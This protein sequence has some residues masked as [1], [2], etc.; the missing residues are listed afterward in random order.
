MDDSSDIQ[1]DESD[2]ARGEPIPLD[3]IAG[4]LRR[5][6]QLRSRDRVGEKLPPGFGHPGPGQA[7]NRDEPEI[8]LI[9]A[10]EL[11]ELI[12]EDIEPAPAPA[13]ASVDSLPDSNGQAPRKSSDVLTDRLVQVR[14][15]AETAERQRTEVM[16]QNRELRQQVSGLRESMEDR[17]ENLTRKVTDDDSDESAALRQELELVRSRATADL[18]TLRK[19]LLEVSQVND[20]SRNVELEAELQALRQEAAVLRHA[21]KEKDK[22]LEDLASQCRNLEDLVEDRD[23]DLEQLYRDLEQNREDSDGPGRDSM[24]SSHPH[25]PNPSWH[26]D[27]SPLYSYRDKE[28]TE[29]LDGT[30]LIYL[31]GKKRGWKTLLL[32]SLGG[33]ALGVLALEAFFLSSGRGEMFTYLMQ[34]TQ[35]PEV[36]VPAPAAT[37]QVPANTPQ[38]AAVPEKPAAA[39]RPAV[40]AAAVQ[41][42][43]PTIAANALPQRRNL[44]D[45]LRNGASG[46]EMV[47]LPG[48]EFVMGDRRA[49]LNSISTPVHRVQIAPLYLSKTEVSFADYEHFARA[50]SRP[51]P[52]DEGW[53]RGDQP[54]INV[55]WE[56]AVAYTRWLSQQ[57]GKN[58]RLPTEAEWEYAARAGSNER[59]WWGFALDQGRAICFDCGSEWD[60]RRTAPVGSLTANPFG[61]HDTAGNVMEWVQDCYNPSYQDAPTDGS[62]WLKGDCEQR[63]VRGGAYNKPSSSLRSAARGKMS[64][65]ARLQMLGFR[66]AREL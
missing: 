50:T 61:L 7:G 31:P 40:A 51:I 4:E 23:R 6:S 65:E 14:Q 15:R 49:V 59:Y 21:V 48:G 38:A 62:A 22:V 19:K 42:P 2:F 16:A 53:G 27:S 33:L 57:T 58:Y 29:V 12:D 11:E 60:A 54:V 24:P 1:L 26:Q 39:L 35:P 45:R 13:A 10:Q 9:S 44:R 32:A 47:P 36:P 20:S 52:S 25:H 8:P 3:I 30:S 66:V 18:D 41:P 63:V 46:P 56:D 17:F 43:K 5:Q 55:N 28:N 34:E 64:R 37:V